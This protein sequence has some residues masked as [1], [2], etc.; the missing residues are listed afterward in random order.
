MNCVHCSA[1]AKAWTYGG[2]LEGCRGCFVRMLAK[3][4]APFRR[5]AYTAFHSKHKDMAQVRALQAEVKA[6]HERIQ[7]LRAAAM[8]QEP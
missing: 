8:G 1:A 3:M 5:Q 2:Y 6:E 7:A 4:P